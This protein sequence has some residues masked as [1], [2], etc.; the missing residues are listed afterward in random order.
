METIMVFVNP[1]FSCSTIQNNN[2]KKKDDLSLLFKCNF[3]F[4]GACSKLQTGLQTPLILKQYI[5]IRTKD[6]NVLK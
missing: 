6:S 1:C 3:A 4:F 2:N 5:D